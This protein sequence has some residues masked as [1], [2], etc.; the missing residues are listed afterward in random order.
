MERHLKRLVR[1]LAFIRQRISPDM[2]CQQ[3]ALFLSVALEDGITMAD[4]GKRLEMSQGSVSKN[5]RMLSRYL[6]SGQ[7]RGYDLVKA[8]QDLAERR[9]FVV[10]LTPKGREVAKQIAALFHDGGENSGS[11][12]VTAEGGA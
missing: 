6:E 11:G 4:L 1:V 8:E 7:L 2:P 9:R 12:T 10:N 5:V 3:L